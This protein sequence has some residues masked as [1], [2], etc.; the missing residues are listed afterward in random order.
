MIASGVGSE[1]SC[2]SAP[3]LDTT[4]RGRVEVREDGIR[5][6]NLDMPSA[7]CAIASS[8]CSMRVKID[9]AVGA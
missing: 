1:A 5:D 7:Y 3:I 2:S 9:G 6:G 8:M 4:A